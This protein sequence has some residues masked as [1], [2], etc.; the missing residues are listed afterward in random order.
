MKKITTESGFTIE[1]DE[2]NFDDMELLEK[3]AQLDENI[4]VLPEV[5]TMTLGEKGKKALYDHF[6]DDK[7]RATASKV[8]DEF[9]EIM[10]L[11]GDGGKNS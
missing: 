7:G 8:M 4:L 11:V 3:L 10:N 5:L 1:V 2:K 6:R 9:R